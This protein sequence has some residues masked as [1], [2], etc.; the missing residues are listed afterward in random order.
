MNRERE[1]EMRTNQPVRADLVRGGIRWGLLT[2]ALLVALP[3]TAE[4]PW[5]RLART[6]STE[7]QTTLPAVP[8]DE[9]LRGVEGMTT[10]MPTLPEVPDEGTLIPA[11]YGDAATTGVAA[12]A[13]GAGALAALQ[14]PKS[15]SGKISL[16]LESEDA[17]VMA[18]DLF[19]QPEI[20]QMLGDEPRFVYNPNGRPDPMLLPWVRNEAIFK[21]LSA[22]AEALEEAGEY[23]AAIALYQRIQRMGDPR[24]NLIAQDKIMAIAQ[25]QAA[26]VQSAMAEAYVPE[27]KVELPNWVAENTTGVIVGEDRSLCLVGDFMLAEGEALPNYPEVRVAAISDKLVTYQV[28]HETFEVELK[29]EQ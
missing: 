18:T 5:R 4:S 11:V 1:R 27:I 6:L 12:P 23:D 7:P 21:E 19:Q 22:Q 10:G 16:G 2:A 15:E 25:A 17:P 8:Q 29:H 20:R 3:A 13:G 24:F 26:Q 9:R 28:Q 14:G